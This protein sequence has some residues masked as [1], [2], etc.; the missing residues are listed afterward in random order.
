M[1]KRNPKV[2]AYIERAQPFAQPIL[3][4]IRAL[5]HRA[6]PDVEETIKWGVPFFEYKG[7][8]GGM[9]GFKKH[10]SW[11][12]WKAKLI[13]L[14]GPASGSAAPFM[15]AAKLSHVSELPSDAALL[16]MMKQAVALNES[17]T[18]I[19]RSPGG[20]KPPPKVPP[21]LAAALKKNAKAAAAFKAFSPS[22]QR[23]YVEWITGAKQDE[24]RQRR[25]KQA[26]EMMA[27][28]KSR[29]WKYDRG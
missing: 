25:L 11:G 9:A 12:L 26:I 2:D 3:T 28:G 17:G 23:E 29:N 8:L 4:K 21:D 22:H 1:A 19:K 14:T 27:Q 20:K 24:T 10:A 18:E 16:N 15:N 13:K 6:C 7:T 5:F